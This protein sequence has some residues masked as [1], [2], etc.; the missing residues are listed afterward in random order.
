[1]STP[2]MN[3]R[4]S[5]IDNEIPSMFYNDYVYIAGLVIQAFSLNFEETL[6]INRPFVYSIIRKMDPLN[7]EAVM[8]FS[9]LVI[10]PHY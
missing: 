5:Q 2:S 9:G 8:L 10:N 1:M 3:E 4:V 6:I 7:E